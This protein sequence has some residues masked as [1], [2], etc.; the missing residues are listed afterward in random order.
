MNC[1]KCGNELQEGDK[2]C[3]HCGEPVQES[4]VPGQPDEETAASLTYGDEIEVSEQAAEET[5]KSQT[6]QKANEYVDKTKEISLNYWTFI[7][8][9]VKAPAKRGLENRANDYVFGYINIAVF[10]LFFALG[11]YF[12][13]RAA[14]SGL[15]AFLG[16]GEVSFFE[17]FF[18]IFLY[19]AA[20]S[21]I[22]VVFIFAV[23]K[24]IMKSEN[25]SFHDVLARFGALY[26]LPVALS[27]LFFLISIPG[28]SMVLSLVILL[29]VAGLQIA[30]I[31][32]LYSFSQQLETTFDPLYGLF[33]VYIGY[34][35][36]VAFTAD[37]VVQY[38]L[39]GLL[40]F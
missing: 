8:E 16:G 11:T 1:K 26:T 6:K 12:Q 5:E 2:F 35:V 23:L 24:F 34:A 19:S 9:N 3:Q 39:S 14:M 29:M 25:T 15:S 33:L 28:L 7:V 37:I 36:F 4:D 10:A 22:G 32:T 38:F 13:S 21:L 30:L 31:V 17:T 40:P 27:L 20:S 18:T